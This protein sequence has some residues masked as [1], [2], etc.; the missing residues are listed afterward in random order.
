MNEGTN[1][2]DA[3]DLIWLCYQKSYL[4]ILSVVGDFLTRELTKRKY[5]SHLQE[6]NRGNFKIQN[7][8]S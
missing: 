2:D 7:N 1:L 3:R 8:E 4:T 5:Q 6:N